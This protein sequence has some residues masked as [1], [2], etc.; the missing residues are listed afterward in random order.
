MYWKMTKEVPAGMYVNALKKPAERRSVAK[1]ETIPAFL[2]RIEQN[3][4]VDPDKYFL[5]ERLPVDKKALLRFQENTLDP[6]LTQ[7]GLIKRGVANRLDGERT[8][9]IEL[10][11]VYSLIM[12]GNTD[13]CQIYNTPCEFLPLCENNFQ[14]YASEYIVTTTKH[15]ELQ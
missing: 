13:Y 8:S 4:I 7:M 9:G 5:R 12:A 3:I 6:V 15:P 10:A 14:D 2:K 1:A 11:T